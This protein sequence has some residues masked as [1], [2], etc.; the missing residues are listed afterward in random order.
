MVRRY[1]LAVLSVVLALGAGLLAQSLRIQQ[2]EFPLLLV[3]VAITAWNAGML[4]GLLAVA[5]AGLGFDYFFIEPLYSLYM[6]PESWPLFVVFLLF[7]LVIGAFSARRRRI[8]HELQAA[9]RSLELEVAE[10]TRQAS[11]LDLTHDSIF[12]R[13]LDDTITDWNRGAE[14]LFGWKAEQ[15]I[16]RRAHDLMRTVFPVPLDDIRSELLRAGRW[17]GELDKTRADGTPVAV[18]SRWSLR[19][20]ARAQPVAILE[21]NNDITDRRRRERDIRILN[22]S[23][24]QRSAELQATNKELEAFAYSISHDLRAPLRHVA[25][26]AELLQK[27]AAAGLDDRSRR[28]LTVIVDAARRMGNLIDDLLA[29]SRIGRGE[30]RTAP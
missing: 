19:R 6:E 10:R 16:G 15:A 11:L 9:R 24:A 13:D 17:E 22:Q 2:V 8:G 23:L 30:T 28:Y 4:P 7:A 21:T 12:V 27:H 1:G 18:S 14:E 5:L 26:Y 25:G 3:A 20:D 29:F